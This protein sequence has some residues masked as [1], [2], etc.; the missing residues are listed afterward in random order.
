MSSDD[1]NAYLREATGGDFTA[2]DFRTWAAT[3]LAA[4]ALQRLAHF[5]SETEAKRNVLAVID[6]VARKL[7]HTR[8]VCRRSY[9]HPR[10]IGSY[11]A[12][13]PNGKAARVAA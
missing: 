1:V 3:K 4:E 10:V 6:E 8:A 7:G 2:K 12:G 9:V 5:E 13:R 11:L